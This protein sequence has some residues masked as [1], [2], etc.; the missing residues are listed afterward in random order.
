[1]LPRAV[2]G[3]VDMPCRFSRYFDAAFRADF[4]HADDYCRFSLI[5][6]LSAITLIFAD[7]HDFAAM[8]CFHYH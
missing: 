4:R 3:D 1:M 8:L 5:C 6:L 7:F 2:A